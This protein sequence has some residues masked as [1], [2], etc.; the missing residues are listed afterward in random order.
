MHSREPNQ[1]I[2]HLSHLHFCDFAYQKKVSS[3]LERIRKLK[4]FEQQVQKIAPIQ[5]ETQ[6]FR[7][8]AAKNPQ[9][10]ASKHQK[11]FSGERHET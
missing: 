10:H 11:L 2:Q 3:T 9:Q 5:E 7:Y 4:V 1:Y 6:M 8:F